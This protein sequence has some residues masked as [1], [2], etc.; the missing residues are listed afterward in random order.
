MNS[1]F[2]LTE[3]RDYLSPA[4]ENLRLPRKHRGSTGGVETVPSLILGLPPS[5]Q[6]SWE[7]VP[8]V[9]I[10]ALSGKETEDG[11][12]SMDVGIRIAVRGETGEEAENHMHNVLNAVRHRLLQL[13]KQPLAKLYRLEPTKDG[14]VPWWRPDEQVFPF[15]EAFILT[16]WTFKGME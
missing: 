11:L 10:Q 15:A 4:L 13:K 16:T 6:E 12:A 1:F 5:G 7:R 2:L 8:F 9:S 3:L 14:I